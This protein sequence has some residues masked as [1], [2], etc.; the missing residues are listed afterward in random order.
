MV[1][2]VT[3]ETISSYKKLMHDPATAEIWQTAFGKDFGG[4]A[5]GDIKMGQKGTY[6]MFVMTHDKI[7]HI[8]WQGKKITYRNPVV[9][10]RPQK[11]DPYRIRTAGGNLVTYKSS[12]SVCT[13]DLDTAKLHWNSIISTPGATYMCLDIKTNYL[14]A[15]LE[16]FEYM[17]MPLM[18]FPDWIQIQ[19][20]MKELVYNRYIHLEMRQAVWGLPQAGILANKRLRQK[21]A[22]FGYFEHVNTPGLW[23]HESR[24]ISFTLV[25]DDV[26]GKYINKDDV[27]QLVASIK[28]TY[29]LT[30]DW[31]GDLYCGIVLAW[32][33]VNRIVDIL[34]PGYIKKNHKNITAFN[35]NIPKYARTCRHQNN[36]GRKHK[37]RFQ[38][39]FPPALT[40]R[41]SLVCNALWAAFCIMH[42]QWI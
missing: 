14:T 25:V 41:A 37:L 17:R 22:P 15:C 3:R 32:D 27:N 16:Y 28:T 30:E 24:P 11:E 20:N 35:Q 38:P 21:L 26:G 1:H 39:T 23:Y 29:T 31:S 6:A 12:P 34:M 36:S 40:K 13:A 10:Y 42:A 8:L 7:K 33:Y 5:Q 19:Y 2:P 9:N 18:L 4:M